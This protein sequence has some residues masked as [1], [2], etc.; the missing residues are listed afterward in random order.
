MPALLRVPVPSAEAYRTAVR[1]AYE[2]GWSF[3]GSGE[4]GETYMSSTFRTKDNEEIRLVFDPHCLDIGRPGEADHPEL[5][6]FNRSWE[7]AQAS[8]AFIEDMQ[9]RGVKAIDEEAVRYHLARLLKNRGT[10][11]ATGKP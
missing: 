10:P 4:T 7:A 5:A 9:R 2:E 11:H 6:L 8:K 3:V 1:N